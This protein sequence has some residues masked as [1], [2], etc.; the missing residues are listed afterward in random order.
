MN[1]G[2]PGGD[3]VPHFQSRWTKQQGAQWP[4]I[5]ATSSAIAAITDMTKIVMSGDA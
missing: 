1:G 4:C 2:P 3:T 5:S